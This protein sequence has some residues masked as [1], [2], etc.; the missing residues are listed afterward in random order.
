MNLLL[1]AVCFKI[2]DTDKDGQLNQDELSTML[3][4]MVEVR[5]QTLQPHERISQPDI[6][7]MSAELLPNGKVQLCIEDYL[8]WTSKHPELPNEFAKLIY[9]L[10]HVV[11]GLRPPN[12]KS[13][14]DIVRGWLDREEKAPLSPGQVWYLLNMDW[15]TQWNSYVNHD[16]VINKK[17]KQL[18]LESSSSS[19]N[20][21]VYTSLNEGL[22]PPSLS[23]SEVSKSLQ[24]TPLHSPNPSR[25][26]PNQAL[27]Q[28]PGL[29]DNSSLIQSPSHKI[30][31]L[32]GEGGRLKPS[33]KLVRG[34]D[35][36]LI[37]ERLW[38]ALIDWYGGAPAIPRQVVKNYHNF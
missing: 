6:G 29:I 3:K 26:N 32:T 22:K 19:S 36:E 7:E 9:Q 28:R 10:C 18:S 34:K 21:Q 25:K 8:V 5:N 37:P 12:R 33:L 15:W 2:F 30:S 20:D 14:G 35:F 1:L 4:T 38:K 27:S 11:L 13:E 31:S 24:S 23:Q 17:V 16:P